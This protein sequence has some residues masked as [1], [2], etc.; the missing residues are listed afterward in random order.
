VVGAGGQLGRA[1]VGRLGSAIVWHGDQDDLDV[2]DP[3]AVAQVVEGARPDVVFNA[4]AMN[5][6]DRAEDEPDEAFAVNALGPRHLARACREVGALIVHVSTD[7]VF[8]GAARRPYTEEDVPHPINVYGIS[9]LSGELLV[10]ASGAEYLIARTSAVFAFGGSP[11][12]GGSFVERILAKARSGER[13]RV[14]D[15]QVFSP[16]SASDL[17]AAL[18]RLMEAGAHGLLHVTNA[19]A[20]SWHDLATRTLELAGVTAHVDAIP[21]AEFRTAARRP[22][23]SV[24]S[25][26]R[27]R[28][29]GL[30]PLRPWEEALEALLAS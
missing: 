18:I 11:A 25:N 8:D 19:G 23:Y 15:D 14:V 13:L 29:L 4:S 21:A 16:T 27:L 2:R 7:Y 30:A 5:A 1:L 6:V 24:L 26:E 12:K 3:D 17:A 28:S 10:R 20:C 9:K 22:H